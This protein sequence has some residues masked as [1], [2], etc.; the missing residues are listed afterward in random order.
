MYL[1]LENGICN[2]QVDLQLS[3]KIAFDDLR[4]SFSPVVDVVAVAVSVLDSAHGGSLELLLVVV[5]LFF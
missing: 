1:G 4:L 5:S 2:R 3:V